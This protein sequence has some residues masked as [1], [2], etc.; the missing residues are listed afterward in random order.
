MLPANAQQEQ[1]GTLTKLQRTRWGG[2]QHFLWLGPHT[3]VC[4]ESWGQQQGRDGCRETPKSRSSQLSHQQPH[5]SLLSHLLGVV[6]H[7]FG[8]VEEEDPGGLG[9]EDFLIGLLDTTSNLIPGG[10]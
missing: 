9:E 2:R 7:L 8:C 3:W 4:E 6:C 5:V 1:S 10:R